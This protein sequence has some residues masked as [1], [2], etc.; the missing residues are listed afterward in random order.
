MN[1]ATV[2][3]LLSG[4][5]DEPSKRLVARLALVD[6]H[7]E[8]TY[9]LIASVYKLA[10][11][12]A[13]HG[14]AGAIEFLDITTPDWKE[15]STECMAERTERAR[16]GATHKIDVLAPKRACKRLQAVLRLYQ[17]IFNRRFINDKHY[18]LGI[19][20]GEFCACGYPI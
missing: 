10:I 20:A 2:Q 5:A 17:H 3:T 16:R 19:S 15:L 1:E 14:D 12:D 18:S 13:R 6:G 8:N 4:A 9:H 11:R 7:I